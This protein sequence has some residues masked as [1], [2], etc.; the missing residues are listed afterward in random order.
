MSRSWGWILFWRRYPT[1]DL[2]SCSSNPRC[3]V[4]GIYVAFKATLWVCVHDLLVWTTI[5]ILRKEISSA[6][7]L[8]IVQIINRLALKVL[9]CSVFCKRI[10][11]TLT[12]D[13]HSTTQPYSCASWGRC[14][15]RERERSRSVVLAQ[16]CQERSTAP[17]LYLDFLTF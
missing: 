8:Q 11:R 12:S 13:S 10:C 3:K 9:C 5:C 17:N 16:T 1:L 14:K 2:V 15:R 7:Q 4:V 6:P